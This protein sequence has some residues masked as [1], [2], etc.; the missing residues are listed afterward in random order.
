MQN[1]YKIFCFGEDT[2]NVGGRILAQS[3]R[4]PSNAQDRVSEDLLRWHFR[5]CV[6]AN[7]KGAGEP[8]WEEDDFG[9]HNEIEQIMELGDAAER[10][11]EEMFNRLG[12]HLQRSAHELPRNP[13]VLL[14]YSDCV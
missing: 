7:M 9:G 8:F 12:S 14:Q 10:M 6:L 3:A 1:N 4:Q 13:D 11:E 2:Y 5:Q